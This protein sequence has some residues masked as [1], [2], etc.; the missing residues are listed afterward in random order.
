SAR[1]G[2]HIAG[3]KEILKY[4]CLQARGAETVA[5]GDVIVSW[6]DER[7]IITYGN[8][9]RNRMQSRGAIKRE[10]DWRTPGLVDY[11]H[12]GAWIEAPDNL[13]QFRPKHWRLKERIV[14]QCGNPSC[15]QVC[16]EFRCGDDTCAHIPS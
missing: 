3:R 12:E 13:K 11:R 14:H 5:H 2:C 6:R 9:G 8:R 16:S 4:P 10:K 15:P 1:L 7:L